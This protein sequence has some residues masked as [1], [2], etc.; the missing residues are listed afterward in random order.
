MC[1]FQ[2]G[3]VFH[4]SKTFTTPMCAPIIE[5]EQNGSAPCQFRSILSPYVP[6]LGV[7][8]VA[9]F[10]SPSLWRSPTTLPLCSPW[11]SPNLEHRRWHPILLRF[12]PWVWLFHCSMLC[13][14]LVTPRM[15]GRHLGRQKIPWTF[16]PPLLDLLPSMFKET[17]PFFT[18]QSLLP[19]FPLFSWF[20]GKIKECTS[21]LDSDDK[22]KSMCSSDSSLGLGT[23][24]FHLFFLGVVGVFT[25]EPTFALVPP[26][27]WEMGEGI[28]SLYHFLTFAWRGLC[29]FLHHFLDVLNLFITEMLT[30]HGLL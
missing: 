1:N 4:V 20:K 12:N 10:W 22:W 6:W 7:A 14:P 24:S 19:P 13:F 26:F 28:L 15:F 30:N 29:G 9:P 18:F 2:G 8:M 23:F 3:W 27:L 17:C 21:P 16:C 5:F 11:W 25:D